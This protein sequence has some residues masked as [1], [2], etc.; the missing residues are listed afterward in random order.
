[1]NGCNGKLITCLRRPVYSCKWHFCASLADQHQS[2]DPHILGAA[3]GL[4]PLPRSEAKCHFHSSGQ[5]SCSPCKQ[6]LCRQVW[7]IY[8]ISS[9]LQLGKAERQSPEQNI[10]GRSLKK[11]KNKNN[12]NDTV[13]WTKTH[14]ISSSGP[15]LYMAPAA[16]ACWMES[17]M[18]SMLPW[19][20]MAHWLREHVAK[21]TFR[22]IVVCWERGSS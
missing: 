5:H 9:F 3:G 14:G 16:L 8:H 21:T 2:W 6:T 19:K 22:P 13:A 10:Y 18:R 7:I 15:L 4:P 20:S 12:N 17:M 11:N 1:M